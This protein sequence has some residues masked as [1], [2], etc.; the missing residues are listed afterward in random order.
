MGRHSHTTPSLPPSIHPQAA[1][2][3]LGAL[4][5]APS[6]EIMLQCPASDACLENAAIRYNPPP[7]MDSPRPMHNTDPA[8]R[9]CGPRLMKG[10][11][12]PEAP[13][14]E[15]LPRIK[16][17]TPSLPSHPP[18]PSTLPIHLFASHHPRSSS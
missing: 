16:V 5:A 10:S 13:I 12:Y 11:L 14:S 4:H 1:T 3:Q 8:F 15:Y 17:K 18:F 2:L 9:V 7:P 6:A